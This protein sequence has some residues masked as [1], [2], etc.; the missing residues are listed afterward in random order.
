[1]LE[2]IVKYIKDVAVLRR[3]LFAI[4]FLSPQLQF[5]GLVV[6]FATSGKTILSSVTP[7]QA[8][9][10]GEN[11]Q[12]LNAAAFDTDDVLFKHILKLE[13]RDAQPLGIPLI[14][15]NDV[16][17]ICGSNLLLRK[18]RPARVVVYDS[19][20][21]TLPASHFHKYCSRRVCSFTQ[22]Y[23]YYTKESDQSCRAIYNDNWKSLPF[24]VSSKETAFSMGLLKHL[25]AEVV[26]GQLS[27][28][29]CADIYNHD[30]NYCSHV[31]DSPW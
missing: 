7:E 31:E 14:S 23:G 15:G 30:H 6:H 10:L 4:A 16:C 17:L 1:M 2:L 13:L 18:D 8:R 11:I 28:K 9:V 22:Y 5:W 26:I 19:F 27:Y 3:M 24:F 12:T 21:G 25:D 29:Q 20:R